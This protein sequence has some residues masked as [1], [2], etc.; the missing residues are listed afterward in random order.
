MRRQIIAN[1]N[2]CISNTVLLNLRVS[3]SGR[4]SAVGEFI[5]K[6]ELIPSNDARSIE[7]IIFVQII[8]F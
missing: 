8:T 1:R 6:G 4:N 7:T 3:V 5:P 2:Q